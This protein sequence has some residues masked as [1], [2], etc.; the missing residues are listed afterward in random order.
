MS[1]T[2]PKL[3]VIGAGIS[4]LSAAW[5]LRQKF[6]V[7]LYEAEPRAGGHADTQLVTLDGTAV[8]VDTGFI[9]FNNI[10][11]PNLVGFFKEL[12]IAAHDSNMSFGVSK[13]NATFEYAGGELKQLF[14]QPSNVLKPRFWRLVLDI[15]RFNRQAPELLK[16]E[17][18]Q[19]LGDYLIA[20]K[21]SD[22]FTED[23][24]LPMGAAIWS[25]SVEGMKA[26]PARSFIRFFVNHG[27]LKIN[28]RPQWR[29]VT[30]GSKVY[31][32]RVLQDLQNVKLG[33]AVKKVSRS[34]DGVVVISATESRVFDQ[35]VFAS[36]AD[37]TLA[38]IDQPT[39]REFEVLDAVKFQPNEAVLHQDTSLMPRRKLAWSS[40]NYI[41]QGRADQT[42]AVCLTYWMNLLQG[43]QTRLP[44]LVSLN[45][46][47]PIDP[48]KVL[49]RKT[50]RHPQF[51][52]AAMQAQED[53]HEIQGRDRLWFAGAWTCWGF[54]EDG[55]ASAVRIANAL[56]VQAPWQTS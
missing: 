16:T 45:P 31:V 26:F 44:L 55:I 24:V 39:A 43:M 1:Q 46:V 49:M 19:S 38:M 52:A 53:L 29:T 25:S 32:K 5:L 48:A 9:V 15:L 23:Y 47:I 41:S 37:A 56:G 51:N 17:S 14:A 18:T 27:L 2:K 10:N 11:Y 34:T 20:N 6:D 36:H 35:V 21:Y 3:A 22:A 4:G 8:P 13:H 12:G 50:Y 33:D 30:G 7:T 42:Q 40:W 28:D 54:H